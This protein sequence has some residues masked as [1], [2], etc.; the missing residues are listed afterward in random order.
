MW[1]WRLR[2][3]EKTYGK[4]AVEC[5]LFHEATCIIAKVRRLECEPLTV[6]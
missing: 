3:C 6:V 5:A 4:T 1:R 2:L